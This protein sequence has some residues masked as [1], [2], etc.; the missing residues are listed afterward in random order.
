MYI[1]DVLCLIIILRVAICEIEL[2]T[3]HRKLWAAAITYFAID[4]LCA[5]CLTT[6]SGARQYKA[7]PLQ[8]CCCRIASL[9]DRQIDHCANFL[10]CLIDLYGRAESSPAAIAARIPEV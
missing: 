9:I 1:A 3:Q 2:I 7:E 10:R 4:D 6:I 5:K 8:P